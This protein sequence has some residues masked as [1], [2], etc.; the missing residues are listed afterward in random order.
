MEHLSVDVNFFGRNEARLEG[1]YG[2][3]FSNRHAF[4]LAEISLIAMFPVIRW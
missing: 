3:T 1:S 2:F 4:R